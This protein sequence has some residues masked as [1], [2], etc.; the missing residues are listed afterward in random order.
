MV[1]WTAA[2]IPNQAGKTAVVT[3]ANSGI[4]FHTALELAR[5]GARV[6]V[7]V[8][9][10]V[11]GKAAIRRLQAEVPDA[12]LHLDLL[13]LADLGSVHRFAAQVLDTTGPLDLL[14][15][16]AGVMGVPQ[17]LT[18]KD[19][20]ELQFGTNHLGHFALTGLLLPGLMT[21]PGARVVTVTSMAHEQGRIRFDDLQGERSYGPW[22][23]Y[24]QSKLANLLFAFELDR[25]ARARGL[26]LVSMAVHPGVSATNL[27]TAGPR[28]GHQGLLMRCRLFFVRRIGQSAAHGALPSLYAATAPEVAAGGFYGPDG[29]GQLR[30]NPTRVLPASGA[31]DEP[32]AQRLW[33]VSERLTGIRFQWMDPSADIP[34]RAP[35]A[36][37]GVPERAGHRDRTATARG[38]FG[39]GHG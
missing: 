6:V 8:R 32:M 38:T 39:P 34:D 29:P 25:Q 15:N 1:R 19:G 28:L 18:T 37:H 11:K 20:F 14:V 10:E 16:S 33:E 9:D 26:D 36:P 12:D 31:L 27:Q 13:D 23:A 3:G 24:S 2:D 4:G 7:A 21:R 35:H 30:G 22:T 17:R 5:A